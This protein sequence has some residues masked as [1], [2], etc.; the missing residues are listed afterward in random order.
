M[1]AAVT[2]IIAGSARGRRLAVPPA[3][4]R[5]TSDRV[6]EALFASVDHLLGGFS[7]VRVLDL[8]A[9]SGA[10]GLEAVSRGAAEAVLVERDRRTAVIARD[11]ARVVAGAGVHVV[12]CSVA[13][14]LSGP[15]RLFDL[16]LLDPPYAAPRAELESVLSRL[17]EAWLAP[18]AVLVVERATSGGGLSWPE[19]VVALREA[20]YGGTRLWYG[21]RAPEREDP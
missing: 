8:Y 11:N 15:P 7:G 16:V 9:G 1:G 13:A 5:P 19:R 18:G 12:A 10:L 6:R 14:Y 3:G 21:R 4:T 20:T 17:A 2:R